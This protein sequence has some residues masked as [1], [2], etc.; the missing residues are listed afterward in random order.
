MK[1]IVWTKYGPPEVLQLSEV[2][3][4]VPGDRE[5]CIRIHNTTV[6]AGDCETRRFEFIP[7][8][9]LLL[10]FRFGLFKPR[11][12]ILGQELAGV[13]ESAGKGVKGFKENDR[14]LAATMLKFG[15]YAEYVCL[16]EKYPIV[17][18]PD[19]LAFEEAATVPTGGINGLYFVR[20]AALQA[21]QSLLINGSGG[22]IGTY[23][24]QLAKAMG[25][26]VTC[27]DHGG[28]L[29]ML[30]SIGADHVIDYKKED[31]TRNGKIYDAIID[32]VGKI[33]YSR[34]IRS[35]KPGGR[36]VLGNPR[37][38]WALRG[39]WTSWTTGKKI[40]PA[41]APYHNED[42]N[43]LISH[44]E[45]GKIKPVI[46]KRFPLEEVAEAHRF[47]ET[48]NKTGNLIIVVSE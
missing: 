13:V 32:V 12:I 31:F 37:L 2:E 3:K 1:A 41:L 5:V 30:R 45:S 46:E 21:G 7:L 8:L 40:I 39:L 23:A 27:V 42:F 47:V 19:S 10:R 15:A 6:T 35:L 24:V 26:E 34:C 28:K 33:S 44:I 17:K 9:W 29:D 38:S 20:K 36:L 14:V 4:P 22:S 16:P 25:A 48:G 11:N 18:I 43:F